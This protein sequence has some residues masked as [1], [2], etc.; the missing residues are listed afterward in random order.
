MNSLLAVSEAGSLF[1]GLLGIVVII[2]VVL[3][4]VAAILMPLYVIGMHG[5]MTKMLKQL[6]EIRWY[7]QKAHERE[8]EA[9]KNRLS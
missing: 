3:L 9:R 6:D 1:G 5:K 8:I 7:A 2:F 4:I